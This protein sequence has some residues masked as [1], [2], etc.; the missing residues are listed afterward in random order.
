MHACWSVHAISYWQ[1]IPV[2][3]TESV[4]FSCWPWQ[5][6]PIINHTVAGMS[7]TAI[8][9][10]LLVASIFYQPEPAGLYVWNHHACCELVI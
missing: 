5:T 6:E 9:S 2:W 8:S 1:G 10:L 4:L 3:F 7:N